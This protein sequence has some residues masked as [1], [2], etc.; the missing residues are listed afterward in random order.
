VTDTRTPD[1]EPMTYYKGEMVPRREVERIQAA[2]A[3]P[4]TTPPPQEPAPMPATVDPTDPR[5]TQ[6][7]EVGAGP[8]GTMRVEHDPAPEATA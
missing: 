4:A 3:T 7:D 1:R 6:R 5:T 2:E 8:V